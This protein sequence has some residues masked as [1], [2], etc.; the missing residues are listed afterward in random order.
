[1]WVPQNI[2]GKISEIILDPH[3]QRGIAKA[4]ECNLCKE[5]FGNEPIVQRKEPNVGKIRR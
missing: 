1:M 3:L 5:N 4:Q 2:P